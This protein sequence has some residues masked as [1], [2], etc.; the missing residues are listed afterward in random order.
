ML[1]LGILGG[2]FIFDSLVVFMY[3]RF[4]KTMLE[5]YRW[6]NE[7]QLELLSDEEEA[8][9]LIHD[10]EEN[11]Q[12]FGSWVTQTKNIIIPGILVVQLI[13]ANVIGGLMDQVL[14]SQFMVN[15][16]A[17]GQA[18]VVVAFVMMVQR[19]RDCMSILTKVNEEYIKLTVLKK[20][21]EIEAQGDHLNGE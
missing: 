9:S 19:T 5:S 11:L 1:Q 10:I 17:W 18:G 12:L 16:V 2:L 14:P 3:V 4:T 6:I 15:L 20:A 7:K 8:N 13:S 21:D